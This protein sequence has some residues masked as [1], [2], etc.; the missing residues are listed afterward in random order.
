M[1]ISNFRG[2]KENENFQNW[3]V[4]AYA[5]FL[6][7]SR[8]FETHLRRRKI[9]KFGNSNIELYEFLES[10]NMYYFSLYFSLLKEAEIT[11]LN[12]KYIH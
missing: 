9:T 3:D 11:S 5:R 2:K 7:A 8:T 1:I 10:A 12:M 4:I 6:E